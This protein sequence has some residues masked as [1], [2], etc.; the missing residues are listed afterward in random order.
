M[1]T[2]TATRR[3]AGIA[4]IGLAA[5]LAASGGAAPV[6]AAPAARVSAVPAAANPL[7]GMK[8]SALAGKVPSKGGATLAPKGTG[9]LTGRVIVV[10][11]GHNGVYRKSVNTHR[12]AAGNGKKKACNSSGTATNAGFAEHKFTWKTA[13]ELVRVLR[14][15]G[16]KVVLTRP[17]DAGTGPCVNERAAIG[18]RA[19]A[20]LVVSIHADGSYAAGARGFHLIL[21]PT[22][23]GGSAVEAR[24]RALALRLRSRIHSVTGMPRSTYIGK[25]TALSV[26]RDIAGL[27]LSKIPAVMLEAGNMRNRRDVTLLTSVAFRQKLALALADGVVA[28]LKG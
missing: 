3:L 18:N 28:L 23:V 21:S 24:S 14:S 7:A 5:C 20:D 10:D 13:V 16:A 4:A 11:P 17:N 1:R 9:P 19:H 8:V 27:N 26:R 2:P 12:V 25:G 22:M 6:M 15:R